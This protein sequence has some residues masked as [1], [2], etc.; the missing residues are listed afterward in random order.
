MFGGGF[1]GFVMLSFHLLFF[2][3]ARATLPRVRYDFF[4]NFFWSVALPLLVV[5]FFF[6]V[7]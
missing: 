4:V 7:K 5:S 1:V 2:M 3:W 6:I